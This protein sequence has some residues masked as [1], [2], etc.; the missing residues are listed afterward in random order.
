M[1]EILHKAYADL[2]S[3]K[4]KVH[5]ATRKH[6]EMIRA[7][8][9][10]YGIPFSSALVS[11]GSDYESKGV[12]PSLWKYF[13][14][15]AKSFSSNELKNVDNRFLTGVSSNEGHSNISSERHRFFAP[16]FADLNSAYFNDK[17]ARIAKAHNTGIQDSYWTRSPLASMNT[18]AMSVRSNGKLTHRNVDN[19]LGVRAMTVL[20]L[21]NLVLTLKTQDNQDNHGSCVLAVT[22]SDLNAPHQQFRYN[23]VTVANNSVITVNREK[24]AFNLTVSNVNTN[25]QGLMYKIINKNNQVVSSGRSTQLNNGLTI[26]GLDSNYDALADGEYDI[27]L[28]SYSVPTES[29]LVVT[30]P[31]I[32]KAKL[33]VGN[34]VV[35]GIS[36]SNLNT[37]SDNAN[38]PLVHSSRSDSLTKSDRPSITNKGKTTKGKPTVSNAKKRAKQNKRVLSINKSAK[39]NKRFLVIKAV[40][41]NGAV[42][43]KNK[44][45]SLMLGSHVL[46]KA[47]LTNNGILKLFGKRYKRFLRTFYRHGKLRAVRGKSIKLALV[48][49]GAK[50]RFMFHLRKPL[51]L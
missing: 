19:H 33:V 25:T 49:N 36:R 31:Q 45:V 40:K 41:F 44:V 48:H 46:A 38:K 37:V 4:E 43:K 26:N 7:T 30:S 34:N 15:F 27:Y 22:S 9:N 35:Q 5:E 6:D 10:E 42:V 13:N 8:E 2:H 50:V 51:A 21:D 28:W 32:Q 47:K 24:P 18:L 20:N 29:N 1:E 39:H 23:D 3:I 17:H 16:S 14:S 12:A 11:H